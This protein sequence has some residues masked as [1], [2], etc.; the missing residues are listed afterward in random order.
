MRA[1]WHLPR[2]FLMNRVV[3]TLPR[4]VISDTVGMTF[5]LAA[6]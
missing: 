6:E 5:L 4:R 2:E 1:L 3:M